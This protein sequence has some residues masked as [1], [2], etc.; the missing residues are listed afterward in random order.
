MIWHGTN[1][2]PDEIRNPEIIT[3]RSPRQRVER[4]GEY[5]SRKRSDVTNLS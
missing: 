1:V 5:V 2:T 3:G 4:D